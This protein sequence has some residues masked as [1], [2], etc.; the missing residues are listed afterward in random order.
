MPAQLLLD[1]L[2]LRGQ[3]RAVDADARALDV[4]QHRKQ[5]HLQVAKDRS[6][7]SVTSSGASRFDSC[8]ARSARSPAR[9]SAPR[10]QLRERQRLRAAAAH[11]LLGQRLVAEV[12]ERAPRADGRTAWRRAGSSP[13]S[14]RTPAPGARCR[15]RASTIGSNFRSWPTLPNGRP[16]AAASDARA[17][18]RRSI[19]AAPIA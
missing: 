4:G 13:A 10:R 12:L 6:S 15:G 8:R 18:A 11:V 7:S 16:R 19:C 9:S 17:P 1:V 3:R 5:R 2:R 14:S